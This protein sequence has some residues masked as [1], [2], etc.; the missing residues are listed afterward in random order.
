MKALEAL[1]IIGDVSSSQRG[2]FTSAQ[3]VSLGLDR[4]VLSRLAAHGQIVPVA[5]GVYRVAAAPSIR[6]EDVYAAWLAA[7]PST[8]A[9]LRPRGAG[10]LTASLG[11]AAWLHDLGE[12]KP[13]PITFSCPQRKQSRNRSVR[14]IKRLLPEED[15]CVV[16]G[17]PATTPGRTVLDLIDYGEDLSLV[18]SAL[19]DAV[20]AD[21]RIDLRT[22]VNSRV[23]KCG[24][25][26]GFDLYSLMTEGR[27]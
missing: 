14:F 18:A 6:E 4:M 5:R 22:Q 27:R 2:L 10:G 17:I 25:A 15:V 12:L 16:A 8:P 19:Q 9:Y 3:V 20:R 7:D 11:T 26:E 1:N 24:F 23:S 13:E 21:P